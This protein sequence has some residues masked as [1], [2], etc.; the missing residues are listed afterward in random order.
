[1]VNPMKS[2]W[3]IIAASAAL[4]CLGACTY[5]PYHPEKSDHEWAVDHEA[6]EK[7]VWEGIRDE[8]GR[9]TYDEYDGMRLIRQCMKEKGWQWERTDWFRFKSDPQ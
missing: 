2:K 1:M 7:S 9:D 5:K 4:V 6:C 3:T 8:P